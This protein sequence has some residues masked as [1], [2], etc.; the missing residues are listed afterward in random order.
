MC[1]EQRHLATAVLRV[2]IAEDIATRAMKRLLVIVKLADDGAGIGVNPFAVAVADCLA[3][4]LIE[5]LAIIGKVTDD[6]S[7]RGIPPALF[8]H[9]YG[10]YRRSAAASFW[11]CRSEERRVGKEC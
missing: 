8:R 10:Y 2:E 3:R 11:T 1:C 7:R 5:P 4:F 9:R 6:L